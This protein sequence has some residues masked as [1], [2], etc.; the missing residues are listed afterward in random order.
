MGKFDAVV[1]KGKRDRRLHHIA[2]LSRAPRPAPV[3][4]SARLGRGLLR[5]CFAQAPE[6]LA[7]AMERLKRL[8]G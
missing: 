3:P 1:L 4:L 7:L 8:L 2:V 6:L 5:L